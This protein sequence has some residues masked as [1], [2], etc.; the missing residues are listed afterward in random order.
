MIKPYDNI[1]ESAETSTAAVEPETTG[2]APPQDTCSLA[3][4]AGSKVIPVQ[5]HEDLQAPQEASPDGDASQNNVSGRQS[6]K[7]EVIGGFEVHPFASKFPLLVGQDFEAL[8][9]SIRA[10]GVASDV[11]LH[12][13]LLID[14][15]NRVRAVEE[16]RRQGFEVPL[17][18][19]EWIPSGGETVEEH[20]FAVNVYRRHLTDDQRAVLA[21]ELLP[22]IRASRAAAQ[23]ATRFGGDRR[24]TAA[25]KSGPPAGAA[26]TPRSRQARAASSTAGQIAKLAKVSLHK[27]GQA[28]GLVDGVNAGAVAPE[29]LDAVRHGKKSLRLAS[30]LKEKKKKSPPAKSSPESVGRTEAETLFDAPDEIATEPAVSP[31]TA[32]SFE[33]VVQRAWN[34]LKRGFAVADHPQLRAVVKKLIS[35]EQREFGH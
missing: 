9:E 32:T 22:A 3:N 20:I 5:T 7:L 11:E 17:N 34:R 30:P 13:G 15:R 2:D 35:D 31:P 18:P 4:P 26:A 27:A 33:D 21:T 24:D 25:T 16:L 10:V 28:V 8:V 23:A 19:V 14:G 1:E 6:P 12:G 29:T